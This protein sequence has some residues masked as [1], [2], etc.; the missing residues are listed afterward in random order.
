MPV[1]H[2]AGIRLDI[3]KQMNKDYRDLIEAYTMRGLP[4]DQVNTS[5]IIYKRNGRD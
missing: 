5:R 2:G 1:A 3:I 4:L